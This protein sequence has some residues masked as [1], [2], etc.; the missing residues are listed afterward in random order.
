[1]H[2]EGNPTLQRI[3]RRIPFLLT[4]PPLRPCAEATYTRNISHKVSLG[5]F[6][7]GEDDSVF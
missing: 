6:K 7:I 5:S 4:G 1:M 3:H 2:E